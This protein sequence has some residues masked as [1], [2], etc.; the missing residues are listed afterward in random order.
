MYKFLLCLFCLLFLTPNWAGSASPPP[1]L[2]LKGHLGKDEVAKAKA[3]IETISR[4]D[5]QNLMIVISSSSADLPDILDLAKSI[6]ALKILKHLKVIVYIDDSAIGPSA[7][8]PF[9][10]DELYVSLFVSWGDI[11]LGYES[12]PAN[13]L[14]NR[15]QSLIDPNQPQA[16]LLTNLAGAMSDSSEQIVLKNHSWEIAQ[17]AEKA[18]PKS[19]SISGQTLVI[20]QNQLK[21]L[22]LVK[23]ILPYNEFQKSMHLDETI[24]QPLISPK[25]PLDKIPLNLQ[26]KLQEQIHFNPD[27]NNLAG[28]LYVGDR[29]SS[30]NQSTWL[31]IK[32]GLEFYKQHKPLLIILELDTPGGEVFAAQKISDALK[33]LIP[34][35]TC[36]LWLSSTIGQYLPAPCWLTPVDLLRS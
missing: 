34:N 11:P 31:Y 12:Y 18:N 29:E 19:I 30:I 10:A 25:Y 26:E 17:G 27:G 3:Y 32:Q 21:E 13:V 1:I 33:R 9:L 20:N 22:G 35:T 7:I 6:Y 5:T 23:A 36:R 2:Q 4:Q 24:E 14:R 28:Y 15:V 8:I 16:F